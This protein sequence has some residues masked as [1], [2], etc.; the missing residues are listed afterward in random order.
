[1][2]AQRGAG[3]QRVVGFHGNVVAEP[4]SEPGMRDGEQVI[5]GPV[6]VGA[7][8]WGLLRTMRPRQWVKNV[9][10]FA[11]PLASGTVLQLD[12][13]LPTLAAFGLFCLMAS[14]IY[15]LNDVRDV[16][17]DRRH[18][19]KRFRP[20]AAGIVPPALAVATG[21]FL[22]VV[23]L[24]VA[25]LLTRPALAG[26][27]G[28][29]AAISLAYAYFLKDQP[30]IDLAVVASGFLLRGIAGGAA[31]G[32]A[33]SQWFLLVAAFGALFMVAG[34][35]YAELVALGHDA[36]TRRSLQEYSPSY[37][38]FVWSLSAGVA[39][40]AYSL[41]A[42]EMARSQDGVPWA[43]LSIA[44]FVLGILRYAMDVDKGAAG[45]PE[46]II[47]GDR[48]LLALGVVWALAVGVGVVSA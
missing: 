15:L 38:R 40:T 19:R 27:L 16:A 25:V 45:A 22:L 11:A 24:V 36:E 10:V 43:T 14:A 26:V 48:V 44:P 37:L 18:P 13:L 9:L 32:I 46:E 35:R 3:T 20:V 23:S 17:E 4:G 8:A 7:V 5:D 42:F 30:V 6:S 21:L 41:W 28:S 2:D 34:K 29:Y 31:A 1:M 47:M 39:C 12:V 33:L